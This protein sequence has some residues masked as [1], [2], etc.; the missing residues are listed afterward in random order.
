[1]R[2]LS[3]GL[4]AVLPLTLLWRV[5]SVEIEACPELPA[6]ASTSLKQLVGTPIVLLD[7]GR[8]RDNIQAWPGVAAVEVRLEVPGTVQISVRPAEVAGSIRVGRGWRAVCSDGCIGGS[9][10]VRRP[11][12]LAGFGADPRELAGA[13]D[14]G[15]R[16]TEETGLVVQQLRRILPGDLEAVLTGG[17][18]G[19]L[20]VVHVKPAGSR[21]ERAWCRMLRAGG[22]APWADLRGELQLVI[23]GAR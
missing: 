5:Q 16:L 2:W 14:V 19:T 6:S 4:A 23:G 1:M 10:S 20:H 15:H 22:A 18:D 21:A 8:V 9:L 11:P 13:L 17:D 7:L 12:V 3:L